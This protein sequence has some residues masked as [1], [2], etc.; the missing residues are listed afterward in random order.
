MGHGV[1]GVFGRSKLG[2]VVIGGSLSTDR[3]RVGVFT[4]DVVDEVLSHIV[5]DDDRADGEDI[6][7]IE[8]CYGRNEGVWHAMPTAGSPVYML[9]G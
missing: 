3:G 8:E 7:E 5:G 1:S 2:G 9:S 6:G 4:A